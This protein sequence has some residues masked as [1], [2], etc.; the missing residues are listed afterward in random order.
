MAAA[1]DGYDFTLWDQAAITLTL[2]QSGPVLLAPHDSHRHDDPCVQ[3]GGSLPARGVVQQTDKGAIV[4][5]TVAGCIQFSHERWRDAL[6]IRHASKENGLHQGEGPQPHE[7]LADH[8]EIRGRHDQPAYDRA[9]RQPAALRIVVWIDGNDSCDSRV[10]ST[11]QDQRDGCANGDT[12]QGEV[13]EIDGLQKGFDE[14]RKEF[15]VVASARN[16]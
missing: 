4:V 11:R 5:A 2:L 15:R 16:V 3:V 14:V 8:W 12:A 6:R 9:P 13:L 7:S 10:P 1:C